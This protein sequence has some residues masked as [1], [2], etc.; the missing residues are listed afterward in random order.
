VLLLAKGRSSDPAF[1]LNSIWG[2]KKPHALLGLFFFSQMLDDFE[3]CSTAVGK[4]LD[5]SNHG[6]ELGREVLDAPQQKRKERVTHWPH[7]FRG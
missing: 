2:F 3:I 1:R 6:P 4:L 7:S 5:P